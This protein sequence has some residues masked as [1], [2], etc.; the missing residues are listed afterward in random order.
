MSLESVRL[1]LETHAPD[2]AIIESDTS[3]ATVA[4]AAA[5]HGVA[6]AQ[7]AKTLAF[8]VDDTVMLLVARGDARLDNRKVKA[9]LGGRMR[10]LD[11]AE[12]ADV[13]GHPVGG[14]CPFGLARP[15]PV[16]LDVSIRDFDVVIVAAG[17][18]NACVRATPARLAELVGGQ[19]ADV[20]Q[21]PAGAEL[22]PG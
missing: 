8:R 2:M 3:T 19:W 22:P 13:T 17:A 9:A 20:C 14:V 21:A 16:L 10:M 18:T 5:T 11:R 6:P 4:E 12:V 1:F 7:I 15:L